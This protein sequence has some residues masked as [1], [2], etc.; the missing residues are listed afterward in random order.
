MDF[1]WRLRNLSQKLRYLAVNSLKENATMVLEHGEVIESTVLL[2]MI[3][4]VY[5]MQP[6]EYCAQI[7]DPRTWGGGPEIVALSNHFKCPIHVYQLCAER[8]LFSPFHKPTFKLEVCAKFG[9][10]TF[11]SKAPICLLCADGRYESCYY[12]PMVFK[13]G[14]S[15]FFS[16]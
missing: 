1:D 5:E 9:S 8:N 10:P 14:A 3:S 7:L 13:V 11:D 2:Q 15:G 16:H 12:D 6:Q 4:D